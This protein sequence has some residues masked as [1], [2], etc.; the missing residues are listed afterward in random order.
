MASSLH[1]RHHRQIGKSII[2]YL[3]EMHLTLG[4]SSIHPSQFDDEQHLVP[5]CGLFLLVL[6]SYLVSTF[7]D[8]S[9]LLL[10]VFSGGVEMAEGGGG[11]LKGN[12][13]IGI[14]IVLR[15]VFFFFLLFTSREESSSALPCC[16]CPA[17]ALPAHVPLFPRYISHSQ[18]C[19]FSKSTSSHTLTPP[20]ISYCVAKATK[21]GRRRRRGYII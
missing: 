19:G 11:E 21:M 6:V 2:V 7:C 12:R 16:S 4:D 10:V 14:L 9:P 18:G 17:F 15:D 8:S 13:E 5:F 3:T 20:R 1:S